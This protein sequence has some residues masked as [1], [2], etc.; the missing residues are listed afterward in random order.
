MSMHTYVGARYVPHFT[1]LYDVTQAY[2]AL[3]VVDNGLGTSYIAKVP[4]PAGTPLTDT[5][6]WF[7]YGSV[8]GQIINLQNQIDTIVNTDLPAI[9]ATLQSL[10]DSVSQNF[11]IVQDMIEYDIPVGSVVRT[12]GYHTKND[13]GGAL[14]NVLATGTPSYDCLELDNGNFAHLINDGSNGFI[15][16]KCLGAYGDDTHDDS[17]A[18]QYAVANYNNVFIP[19][20]TFKINTAI[21][22]PQGNKL[23]MRGCGEESILH[24]EDILRIHSRAERLS[25]I[26]NIKFINDPNN[27]PTSG[28]AICLG[29]NS[30][31]VGNLVI[32]E[33]YFYACY[34]AISCVEDSNINI[35]HIEDCYFYRNAVY[36]I[37]LVGNSVTPNGIYIDGCHFQASEEYCVD[38]RIAHGNSI[39]I[40]NCV[41]EAAIRTHL[42]FIQCSSTKNII[43]LNNYFEILGTANPTENKSIL[44][45]QCDNVFIQGVELSGNIGGILQGSLRTAFDFYICTQ[46]VVNDVNYSHNLLDALMLLTGAC[47]NFETN[48]N[49]SLTVCNDSARREFNKLGV[50][51]TMLE[52]NN[53]NAFVRNT[54]LASG[55]T[56][57]INPTESPGYK[58]G[59]LYLVATKHG[60]NAGLFLASEKSMIHTIKADPD[61]SVTVSGGS[62]IATNNAES[63][64]DLSVSLLNLTV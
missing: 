52:K 39:N 53:P 24:G 34:K 1:G 32:S 35:L 59:L 2:E 21:D 13:G 58:A 26:K 15:N 23:N 7:V 56:I 54:S 22:V 6:Y 36:S 57:T 43:M 50:G 14:Y 40:T 33:C 55:G 12:M 60:I 16:V 46:V 38:C 44:C 29:Y 51:G 8:N 64:I 41:F 42:K 25:T 63:A 61:V 31:G 5:N 19:K 28:I 30:E 27:V 9:D 3:D 4:T 48:W 20:G 62:I 11:E 49:K 10:I 17:G 47:E 18:I 45:S 37:G